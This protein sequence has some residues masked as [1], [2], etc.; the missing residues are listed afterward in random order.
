MRDLF[1][2]GAVFGRHPVLQICN[3]PYFG[4]LP[5]RANALK[6][7]TAVSLISAILWQSRF[8]TALDFFVA[9]LPMCRAGVDPTH[10][11]I[12]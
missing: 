5:T 12:A 7:E 4:G 8:L 2:T 1:T 3:L 6:P 11:K 10:F 9:E